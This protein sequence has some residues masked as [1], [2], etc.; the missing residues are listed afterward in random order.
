MVK[1]RY[2]ILDDYDNVIEVL[3][4]SQEYNDRWDRKWLEDEHRIL[5][6]LDSK[7]NFADYDNV[8]NME[9]QI[10]KN[11]EWRHHSNPIEDW[12]NL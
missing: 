12:F 3:H 11:G 2:V 8:P 10:F 1:F 4:E 7:Y 5:L 6:D 9:V